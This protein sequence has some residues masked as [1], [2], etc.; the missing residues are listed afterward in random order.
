MMGV[1]DRPACFLYERTKISTIG[2][3]MQTRPL[4]T[5]G[6]GASWLTLRSG[7]SWAHFPI[8]KIGRLVRPL[9]AFQVRESSYVRLAHLKQP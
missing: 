1:Y 9:P 8:W 4:P 6:S 5:A 7:K 2:Q 3:E